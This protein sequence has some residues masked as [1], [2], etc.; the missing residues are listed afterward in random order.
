MAGCTVFMRAMVPLVATMTA[1]KPGASSNALARR[2]APRAHTSRRALGTPLK[3]RLAAHQR[4][5]WHRW[6]S[7]QWRGCVLAFRYFV[8]LLYI[9][10]IVNKFNDLQYLQK[11]LL[12]RTLLCRSIVGSRVVMTIEITKQRQQMSG[13]AFD[14]LDLFRGA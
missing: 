8:D 9:C 7:G 5:Q 10:R 1:E 2:A 13:D 3:W 11:T 4:R 12:Q 6:F 14:Y